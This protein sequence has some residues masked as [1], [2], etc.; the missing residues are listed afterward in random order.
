MK[1]NIKYIYLTAAMLIGFFLFTGGILTSDTC[2]L[3]APKINSVTTTPSE[4][5]IY[6]P[7]KF[8]AIVTARS[9]EAGHRCR[10]WEDREE[11]TRD[12]SGYIRIWKDNH[13]VKEGEIPYNLNNGKWGFIFET[14][15]YSPGNYTAE[16]TFTSNFCGTEGKSTTES[17]EF[18]VSTGDMEQF[19]PGTYNL[20]SFYVKCSSSSEAYEKTENLDGNYFTI[21]E[22]LNATLSANITFDESTVEEYP[23]LLSTKYSYNLSGQV[24][25]LKEG[26]QLQMKIYYNDQVYVPFDFK[27]NDTTI[28]LKYVDDDNNEYQWT[29]SK[30]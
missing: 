8:V 2:N 20:A 18:T 4:P 27:Y 10:A 12:L 3:Q 25:I 13:V 23:C 6:Q 15:F 14:S 24:T 9:S 7:V 21:D 1:Q 17:I 29:F 22:E 28:W 16:T 19:M 5:A 30:P 26:D 11:Q